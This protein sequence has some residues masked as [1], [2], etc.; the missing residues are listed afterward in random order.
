MIPMFPGSKVGHLVNEDTGCWIW[1]GA[2]APNGYGRCGVPGEKPHRTTAAHRYYYER[3]HGPVPRSLD[4][5]HLCRNR[6]CV[7]PAHMEP[8]TRAVNAWRGEGCKLTPSIVREIRA[9]W[10]AGGVTQVQLAKEYRTASMHI[11][12]IVNR[13]VWRAA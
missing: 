4:L 6:R 3:I 5:D 12:N 11:S 1:Q 10:A 13:K 8:V 2:V 7:N 9:R